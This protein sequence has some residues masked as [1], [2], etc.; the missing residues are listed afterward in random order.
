MQWD[1][2]EKRDDQENHEIVSS[3]FHLADFKNGIFYFVFEKIF[4]S[5]VACYVICSSK[6]TT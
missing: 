2:S 6:K 4:T 1:N 3:F 5:F